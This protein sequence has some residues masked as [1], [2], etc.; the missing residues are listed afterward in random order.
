[1]G[2]LLAECTG[3]CSC[4]PALVDALDESRRASLFA[5]VELPVTARG[6]TCTLR[7]TNA[8]VG[9]GAAA[10]EAHA[11]R[12]QPEGAPLAE[13]KFKVAGLYLAEPWRNES[14]AGASVPAAPRT[15]AAA[16]RVSAAPLRDGEAA[17]SCLLDAR[18]QDVLRFYGDYRTLGHA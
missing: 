15:L 6:A 9:G 2:R 14:A 10:E 1:M 13:S 5:A 8:G 7:L 11:Q 4:A 12:R 17:H 16:A 18:Q 3:E